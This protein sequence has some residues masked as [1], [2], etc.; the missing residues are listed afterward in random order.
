MTIAFHATSK[1]RYEIKPRITFRFDQGAAALS[2]KLFQ[3]LAA[4]DYDNRRIT[5]VKHHNGWYITRIDK[6]GFW[7]NISRKKGQI[8]TCI[9]QSK[10]VVRFIMAEIDQYSYGDVVEISVTEN[11]VEVEDIDREKYPYP[12]YRLLVETASKRTI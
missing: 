12:L 11:P 9:I 10:S 7:L 2:T 4:G 3:S 8:T 5:I 6:G 1:P